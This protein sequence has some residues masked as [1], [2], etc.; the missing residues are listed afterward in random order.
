MKNLFLIV[1]FLSLLSIN[2]CKDKDPKITKTKE[3]SEEMMAYFASYEVGTKWVYQDTLDINN[4]DTIELISKNNFDDPMR[5]RGFSL[6]E[7]FKIFVV[8]L[9]FFE[10]Y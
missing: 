1:A 9:S 10:R 7:S 6:D 5:L 4:F 3:L 2:S 8:R